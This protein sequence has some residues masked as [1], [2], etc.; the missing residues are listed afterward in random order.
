MIEI[1][2]KEFNLNDINY[3]NLDVVES[4]N[5]LNKKKNNKFDTIFIDVYDENSQIPD[6]FLEE[7]FII[8]I[9]NLLTVN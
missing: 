6:I 3:F 7:N 1:A 2:K 5:I 9:T 4:I 8:N